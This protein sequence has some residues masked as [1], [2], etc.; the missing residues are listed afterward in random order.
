MHAHERLKPR[1]LY[2]QAFIWTNMQCVFIDWFII[3]NK[4][5]QH[6]CRIWAAYNFVAP[7]STDLSSI[8]HK[9]I[10]HHE[11]HHTCL[12]LLTLPRYHELKW[13]W[14]N[15]LG[16]KTPLYNTYIAILYYFMCHSK[17]CWIFSVFSTVK[18]LNCSISVLHIVGVL[19][20]Q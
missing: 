3:A 9:S 2:R 5:C 20:A 17:P 18:V 7:C 1:W 19:H 15:V 8:L 14:C 13:F 16:W 10:L 11:T 12:N 4:I 6:N